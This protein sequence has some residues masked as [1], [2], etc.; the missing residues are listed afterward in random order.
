[1]GLG[2]AKYKSDNYVYYKHDGGHFFVITLYVKDMLFFSNSK[3]V[4][5]DL[6]S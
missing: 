4:L 2:I 3:T 6:M 5:Y 1:M